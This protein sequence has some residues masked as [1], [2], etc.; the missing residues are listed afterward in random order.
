MNMDSTTHHQLLVRNSLIMALVLVHDACF[1]IFLET[2]N[3]H[4]ETFL[5]ISLLTRE[6]NRPFCPSIEGQMVGRSHAV[7]MRATVARTG[8]RH[9]CG[10][11]GARWTSKTIVTSN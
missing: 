10:P 1:I 5:S 7:E 4:V 8:V 11:A 6:L 2:K 9:G 3:Q